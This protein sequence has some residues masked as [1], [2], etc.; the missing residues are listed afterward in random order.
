MVKRKFV[1]RYQVKVRKGREWKLY[2]P[3]LEDKTKA[4]E[5]AGRLL[6]ESRIVRLEAMYVEDQS[7]T[8]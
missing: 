1:L 8:E 5:I 2:C 6:D 7:P 4:L 3:S